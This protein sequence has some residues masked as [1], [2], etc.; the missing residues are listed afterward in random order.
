MP[1][2]WVQIALVAN[3][4]TNRYESITVQGADVTMNK[5]SLS[6]YPIVGEQK[7]SEGALWLT[8]EGENAW[9]TAA[10]ACTSIASTT[11]R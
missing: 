5:L 7:F 3:D 11:T 1:G 9:S 6:Q 10:T 2:R 4:A 8:L